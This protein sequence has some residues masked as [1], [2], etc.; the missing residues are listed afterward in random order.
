MQ[1]RLLSNGILLSPGKSGMERADLRLGGDTILERAPTLT[2]LAGEPREDLHGAL[3]MPGFVCAHT[4]L[5]SSLVRGMPFPDPPPRDFPET[6]ERIWWKL[7][8]ALDEESV[9]SSALAGAAEALRRGVTTIVDHHS[10]PTAIPGS[11]SHIEKGLAKV[12]LRGILC[13]EVSDRDGPRA[14]DQGLEENLRYAS[15]RR[16]DPLFRGLVGAHASFTLS[17]ESLRLLGETTRKLDAG[18]HMHLAEDAADARLTL[19]RYGVPI[20]NR[21]QNHGLVT[22][23]SVFAHAVTLGREEYTVLARA[24]SWLIHNPRS[25]M[26]NRVGHA[27]I[28]LFGEK[29]ALGTD[30]FPADML[31]EARAAFFWNRTADPPSQPADALRLLFNGTRL[32]GEVFGKRFGDLEAGYGAD[33]VTLRYL[34]P[35]PLEARTLPAHILF[36]LSSAAVESVMVGGE[37]ILRDGTFTRCSEEEILREAS[38]AADRLWRRALDE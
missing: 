4:H 31:E 34:P 17:E 37:W 20:L 3:V 2:P 18:L 8:R 27:P 1:T 11:L 36:G 23:R 32:A 29:A 28:H 24:G 14:R 10:S 12:G 38:H 6:L 16:T 33:L 15:S 19:A 7:D 13:Y 25:N 22:D 30:G 26:N 9:H 35:T 5:Y 21:L